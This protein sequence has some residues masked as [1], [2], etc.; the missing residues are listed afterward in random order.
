MKELNKNKPVQL[1]DGQQVRNVCWDFLFADGIIGIAAIVREKD[2][3]LQIAWNNR[4]R[5]YRSLN[6]M[7]EFDLINVPERIK[8][9]VHIYK[10]GSVSAI[11]STK[12]LADQAL[13]LERKYQCGEQVACH[14]I[15]IP[16]GEG[17]E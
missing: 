2:H 13:K 17:L 12:E 8:G 5:Y 7:S 3:D 15:N 11:Y 1:R 9:W 16:V 14:Y 4:G 10:D 6:T